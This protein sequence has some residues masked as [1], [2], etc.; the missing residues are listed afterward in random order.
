MTDFRLF[1]HKPEEY[2]IL[3]LAFLG[4]AV[5]EI[6]ARETVMHTIG[7]THPGKLVTLTRSYVTCEAQSDAVERI[8]PHLT[9]AEE[10]VF[11]RGRNAKTHYAPHHGDL[12]QY[13]RATGLEALFGH[14]YLSGVSERM[15]EL[16]C[17]AYPADFL[18]TEGE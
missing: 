6:L 10:A 3:E 2:G 16:F 15:H 1:S 12:I 4:D 9:E 11:R 17:I 18:V 7:K 13:K 5:I 8:L 14:L